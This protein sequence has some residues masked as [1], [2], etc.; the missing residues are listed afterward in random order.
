MFPFALLLFLP[1]GAM[2]AETPLTAVAP[3]KVAVSAERLERIDG[4]VNDAIARGD[5]PGAVVVIVH[6]GH[7]V[8]RKAYGRRALKPDPVAMTVDTLFD[9]ASLTKPIA[10]ATSLMV[11]VDQ[12]KLRLTDSVALHLPKFGQ[13]GKE[14]ITVEQLL[15]HTGGLIADNA[16]ADY[17]DGKD[18]AL[19]RVFAL[20]PTTAPGERFVYSDVGYIVLGELVEKLSGSTLDAFAQKSVFT[21]LGMNETTFL[22]GEKLRARSA[23]TEK[24]DGEWMIGEVHDPRAF[25]LGGVAGHAGLFGSADDLAV[26]AQ[27]LLDGGTYNGKRVLSPLAVRLM[28]SPRSIPGGLRGYGW[29]IATAYSGNRGELFPRGEGFGHTGFTGTSL[30]IDPATRTAVILLTNRVH[31]EGKG[32]VTRLR[33]QVATLAAGAL[34][35]PSARPQVTPALPRQ[36]TLTGID[37][38]V[39]EKFARLKGRRIGLVTNHTG[40]DREGTSTID[41]LHKAEGVTLVALFSPE[42]GLRG[43]E[44]QK[45]ADG[46]DE[47]TGL[48]IYSL[49]GERR[50]PSVE[51]LKGIDTLVFDIQDAGC[52]FYTYVST[53]GLVLEAA[54]EQKLR[55]V[56]L[57]RPNPIGGVAVEGPILDAGRESFTA[58]HSLPVR[59]GMTVGELAQMFRAERKL[60]CEMEVVKMEGW[61]RGDLFDRTGLEWVPPSP[62]LCSLTAAL[63][64]PGIGLLEMTNLSVGRG[65]ERPFE[66]VGAPWID[67]RRLAA[68]LTE[69]G[70]PGVSFVALRQ[71]PTASLYKGKSCGGV[72]ILVEDW[73]RFRPVRT[74]V[75]LASTLRRLYPTDWETQRLNVL[76]AHEATE[77]GIKEGSRWSDLEK[78]WQADVKR[79]V[80]RRKTYLLYGE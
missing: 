47:K 66:W 12:G 18:K 26:F 15:L 61:R 6:D 1:I 35:T 31:P 67:G 7:I 79:F 45:V 50:K 77:K 23:P 39:K 41:L 8:Y 24:R 48:P 28:T 13:N 21:P 17:R 76:L 57:D 43:V 22:P 64:Y 2:G 20:T 55:V 59:H 3:E 70:L 14:K 65:T 5:C 52:R 29:D 30:W 58:F 27:M 68:A 44:D 74:G 42:H 46:K 16:E 63:T 78:T 25:R 72:Q 60:T 4:A 49:Y 11:L 69:E 73:S 37:V 56:V 80:D 10:T 32:N 19:E 54:T 34:L 62:N 9:L 33:S 36:E 51:S 38:L 40:R 75:A 53:L 71:T